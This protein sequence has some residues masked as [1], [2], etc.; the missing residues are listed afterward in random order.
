MGQSNPT[1]DKPGTSTSQARPSGLPVP[2]HVKA[3]VRA[4]GNRFESPGRERVVLT[5]TSTDV[6]YGT[7]EATL[8]WQWPGNWRFQRVGVGASVLIYQNAVGLNDASKTQDEAELGIWESLL[9]DG[10]EAFLF[11]YGDGAGYRFLGSRFRTDDGKSPSYSGPWYDIYERVGPIKALN[12]ASSRLKYFCFD[13]VSKLPVMTSYY[14]VRDGKNV[15]VS[16]AFGN[17][18]T[19][20]GQ[21]VPGQVVRTEDGRVVFSLTVKNVAISAAANDGIFTAQ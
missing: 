3:Y 15:K 17:W 12:K 4:L 2:S 19:V 7:A 11:G 20:D 16:T 8:V 13:S 21:R 14:A 6:K 9:D 10:V 5:G 1:A 18:L